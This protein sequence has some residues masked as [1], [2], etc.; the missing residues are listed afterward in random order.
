MHSPRPSKSFLA[1]LV[2]P[3]LTRFQ[4]RWHCFARSNIS[5]GIFYAGIKPRCDEREKEAALLWFIFSSHARALVYSHPAAKSEPRKS[6]RALE[7]LWMKTSKSEAEEKMWNS[8][9]ERERGSFSKDVSA[10]DLW[11][12]R[13]WVPGRDVF[14]DHLLSLQARTSTLSISLP[15]SNQFTLYK[16]SF[17]PEL[18]IFA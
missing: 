13:T 4:R 7:F 14:S 11:Q 12:K 9:S 17:C 5:G 18:K 3:R 15:K 16:F 8:P 10:W 6:T 1:C 2:P